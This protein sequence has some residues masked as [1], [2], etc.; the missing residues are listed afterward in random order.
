MLNRL[1]V[2]DLMQSKEMAEIVDEIGNNAINSLP[3]GYKKKTE[4][5]GTRVVT[6]V[7]ADTFR[8]RHDNLKNNSILKAV[9][10]R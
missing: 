2:R 9:R 4:Q 10:K 3:D 8:A 1:G 6:T 5:K 7:S